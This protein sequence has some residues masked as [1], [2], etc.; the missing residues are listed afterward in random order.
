MIGKYNNS[1][2]AGVAYQSY[3]FDYKIVPKNQLRIRK[4][5]LADIFFSMTE[6]FTGW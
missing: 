4:N 1:E 2:S 6:D 5:E 3:F